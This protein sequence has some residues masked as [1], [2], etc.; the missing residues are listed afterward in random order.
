MG[1]NQGARPEEQNH[2]QGQ[3]GE[4]GPRM[5][6]ARNPNRETGQGKRWLTTL[7]EFF[8][9]VEGGVD[10]GRGGGMEEPGQA[11][12]AR[13]SPPSSHVGKA[14]GLPE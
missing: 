4:P 1:R 3:G 14:S 10:G 7:T 12:T 9:R 8:L 11:W 6:T 13:G 2:G 5:R